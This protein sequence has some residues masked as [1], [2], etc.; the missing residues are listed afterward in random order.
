[1]K[2]WNIFCLSAGVL[3][4]DHHRGE[5]ALEDARRREI[6]GR[7]DFAQVGHH[8]IAGFRAVDG[9]AGDQRLGVGEQVVADP[10]HGQVGQDVAIGAEIV[11]LHPALGR[12]DEGRV[13]LADALR[14]AGGA[15]GVEHHRGVV[16][17]ALLDFGIQEIGVVAIVDAPHFH[18]F[19][20]VVQEGLE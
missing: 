14:L 1:M 19:V 12:G 11:D 13:R 9:E 8:R 6:A 15:R 3:H 4:A 18:Q 7:A 20:N 5:Q 2:W 16:E 17:M 10:G